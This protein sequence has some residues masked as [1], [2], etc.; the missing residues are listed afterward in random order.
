MEVCDE[1]RSWGKARERIKI[2]WCKA[3]KPLITVSL[4]LSAGILG[5]RT[6][7]LMV[8]SN[9][10]RTY[11]DACV[12]SVEVD[13]L[14]TSNAKEVFRSDRVKELKLFVCFWDFTPEHFVN[15]PDML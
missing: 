7:F 3:K 15:R 8:V 5:T 9:N 13:S 2:F 4:C 12:D 11:I 10:S 1:K 6:V 14:Y